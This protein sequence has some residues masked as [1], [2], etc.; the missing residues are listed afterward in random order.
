MRL[1]PCIRLEYFLRNRLSTPRWITGEYHS[2]DR[3][4]PAIHAGSVIGPGGEV[5][6]AA[7][8]RTLFKGR[9]HYRITLLLRTR[10]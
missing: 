10:R 3:T 7:L 1:L 8:A 4:T 2:I 5:R 9:Q 6:L